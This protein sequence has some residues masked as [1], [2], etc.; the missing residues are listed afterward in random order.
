MISAPRSS[1][2]NRLPRWFVAALA[3]PAV[4]L[5]G[6][7]YLWPVV[8]L[9][10]EAVTADAVRTAF[11]DP[12]IRRIIWFT[13]WQAVASTLLTVV[14]GLVPAWLIARYEFAGRRVLTA[15]VTVPFVLPTVVVGAAFLALLPDS[16]DHGVLAIVLAHAFFNIAVVVRGVGG[17]WQQ[18]PPDLVAAARTLGASP[19]RTMRE[20]T[21]PLLAPSIAAAAS[22][23]FLFSFTSFGV[24][25]LLGGATHPTLEVEIWQRATRFGDV[26][27]AAVLSV[28]QLVVLGLAVLWFARIQRRQQFALRLRPLDHRARA[29][30]IRQR[31]TV[32][33][34]CA[35]TVISMGAPLVALVER[36]LRTGTGH[37]LAAWR[38]VITGRQPPTSRPVANPIDALGSL[39]VSAQYAITAMVISVII[40][41]TATFAV[42]AL[43]R[44]GRWLDTGVMLPLGTSAVTIG[45]GLL[46]T[47]DRAPIDWRAEPWLIPLGHALV[48]TPFVV[49]TILPVIRSID[50][51][52]LD[53]A[54]T[55]GA[56][57]LRA[58]REVHL[59][60]AVSPMVTA[61]GFAL[62]I[63]LGEF[64]ATTFLTRQGRA[65]M[66]IAIEQLLNRPGALLHAQGY[67]LATILAVATF[68]IVGLVELLR[69]TPGRHA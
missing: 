48:A 29:R 31:L 14:V 56:S 42:V 12:G 50:S 61:C 4:V 21:L 62:A 40:G 67:V 9:V 5:V 63:S 33:A 69:R 17:L 13:T 57:P 66:P 60:F 25:R 10:V 68:A 44:S 37:S 24:V 54:A 46:I 38:A 43:G 32:V 28:V 51:R 11:G 52:L 2:Q 22:V 8:N 36:S 39:S 58:W 59:G 53:A 19:L 55:L 27:T 26:S 35:A 41:A 16:A 30:N 15:L 18:L 34:V 49:R 45:F 23:V 47:F 6:V 1:T 20:V 7:F 3:A 65:T 64:G